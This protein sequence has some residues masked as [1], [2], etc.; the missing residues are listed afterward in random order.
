MRGT[1]WPGRQTPSLSAPRQTTTT[2]PQQPFGEQVLCG[3]ANGRQAWRMHAATG[4]AHFSSLVLSSGGG[5]DNGFLETTAFPEPQATP[6]RQW[7]GRTL[8]LA[9]C[10]LFG[11]AEQPKTRLVAKIRLCLSPRS[12]GLPH[13]SAAAPS[14]PQGDNTN[15]DTDN[16]NNIRARGNGTHTINWHAHVDELVCATSLWSKYRIRICDLETANGHMK[17]TGGRGKEAPPSTPA[18]AS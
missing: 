10:D 14:L 18:E 7:E 4:C 3:L 16:K 1:C 2:T 9:R 17:T 8:P 12:Q 6:T 15:T 5:G 11:L 13:P